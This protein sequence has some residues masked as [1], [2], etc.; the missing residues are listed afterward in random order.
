MASDEGQPTATVRVRRVQGGAGKEAD[1]RVVVEAP[2]EI[3]I[4]GKPLTVIMRTPGQDEE[5]VL[6]FLYT[7]GVI[8]T[9]ADVTHCS[10][11]P[12]LSG[13]EKGNVLAVE[14]RPSVRRAPFERPFYSSSSCGVCGKQSIASLAIRPAQVH[15]RLAMSG[16][17]LHQLPERLRSA[18]TI[19][20]DTGGV[21]A[22]ALFDQH[23]KLVA[24]RE[25]VGR[26]NA[27]DK[28]VGWA[29]RSGTLPLQQYALLVS[30]RASYE[31][32]QK[33]LAAGITALAA[34]GA[35]SSLAVELAEQF[36]ITL[37]GFLRP[38]R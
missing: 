20:A 10:R 7:E 27:V 33:A 16:A 28:L 38:N 18:Q 1:D 26:H 14:L 24:L 19:F 4:G 9:A 25:D 29:L 21:H 36:D 8:E 37:V 5:L 34:I 31:I 30:G 6:G 35:P 12:G 11:P 32:V 17:V 13:D 15:S 22:A 3:R 23:G 2:L